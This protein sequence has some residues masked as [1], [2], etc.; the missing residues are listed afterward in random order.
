MTQ[1][2]LP[3]LS[4]Q[5]YVD[6]LKRR[7][8]QVIPVSLLGLLIGGIVAFF[9]PRYYVADAV[10]TYWAPP[11]EGAGSAK[12]DPFASVVDTARLTIPTAIEKTIKLLGWEEGAVTDPYE[13][14]QN[15]AALDSRLSVNDQNAGKGRQYARIQVVFRDREGVRAA[16]FVNTLVETWI[17]QRVAEL[18]QRGEED[19]AAATQRYNDLQTAYD[20]YLDQK[21][22]LEKSYGIDPR[23]ERDLQ[24]ASYKDRVGALEARKVELAKLQQQVIGLREQLG[25]MQDKLELLPP[26]VK[27]DALQS[28]ELLTKNPEA[29][30]LALKAR[31][32]EK[33]LE[34][35]AEG[36][37]WRRATQAE[38]NRAKADLAKLLGEAT[39]ESD[40]MMPN[41]E[42]TQL[43]LAI[44]KTELELHTQEKVLAPMLEQTQSDDVQ[45]QRLADGFLQYGRMEK[46]IEETGKSLADAHAALEAANLRLG[47]INKDAPV[48]I[49]SPARTPPR[50]TEPN[51]MIVA[52]IGCVLGLGMAIALILLLDVMQGSFKTIEDVERGLP[53]PVLG[54]VSHLVTVEEREQG[55][56]SRRR[57]TLVS[58]AFVVLISGVVILF[59]WDPTRLPPFVRDLLAMV[60]GAA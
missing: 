8:W 26:R 49:Q 19:K 22:Q 5:R 33:A 3:Q 31:Y 4:L 24:V 43:L 39:G 6:L 35:L 52:L 29:A 7:R 36:S 20:G 44:E 59:Y 12:E 54:G 50:P 27:V 46:S 11:G 47:K 30:A 41:P 53:V 55:V 14:G 57:V 28:A 60:L 9:I 21:S 32:W 15:L 25:Q 10:L 37:P 2:E 13:L 38:L 51:I 45:L 23:F 48:T 17:A 56:R 16:A 18:R 58:A 34:Y 40:G 1:L 42:R